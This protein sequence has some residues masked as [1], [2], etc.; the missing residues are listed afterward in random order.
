M[1]DDSATYV[2]EIEAWRRKLDDSLR[3][4]EGW[5]ALV[6]LHWL[7]PGMNRAGSGA[8]RE[9]SLP[10]ETSPE[11][12][13][14][15][16]LD[17]GGVRF[18]ASSGA[19]VTCEGQPVTEMALQP[20]TT[21]SPTRLRAGRLTIVLIRRGD[22]FGLRVWDRESPARAAFPGRQW[23]PVDPRFRVSGTFEPYATPRPIQAADV[24]GSVQTMQSPGEVAF[25]LL[26]RPL[27]L[28]AA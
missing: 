28:I 22:R 8:D 26:E 5:L 11:D 3:R 1:P 20:D 14:T 18:A 24:T 23:F 2:D 19:G 16:V 25:T 4:E 9:I 27:R 17:G 7:R 15:F 12:L 6:G 10:A 21:G 13:G